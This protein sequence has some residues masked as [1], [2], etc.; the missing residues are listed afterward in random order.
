MN[1][2]L[3]Y[4]QAIRAGSVIVGKWVRLWYEYIVRGLEEGR[5]TFDPKR[6]D[7]AI[8]FIERFCHHCEGRSD[9]LK[10]ALW[11]KALVSV[12][13]GILDQNGSRQFREA[14]VIVAR[15]QGKTLFAAAIIAYMVYL[16]GEYG[17]KVYCIA[18]KL[19]QAA[20]VYDDFCQMVQ[21]EPELAQLSKKRRSDLYVPEWNASVRPIAFNAK[22]SDGFNPQLVVC[23]EIASW[24]AEQGLKQYE[25]MKSALGARR[26]PLVLSISTAGYINDGIY[27]ELLKRCTTVLLGAS[28]EQRLAPFLYMI[29]DLDRW[30]DL[31][32]LA[33][34]NPNL[35]VSVSADYLLEEIAIAEG[36]LSKKTEFLTK[37]CNVKQSSAQAWLPYD[38]IQASCGAALS[39][40]DFRGSYCVGGI[41]LS[42]TTDL[43]ACCVVIEKGGRLYVFSHFF[44][45]RSRLE[46][47][48][49]EDG[50]PYGI[51]LQ[52]GFLTLSGEN[53][54]DYHDCYDWFVRL[55]R[56]YEILPLQVGYDRY[57]AQ[58]LVQEME[59]C[60]F[61]MDDVFQGFNLTPV[62]REFEGILRDGRL[63]IGDNH[64]LQA[65]LL[66][67]ALKLEAEH[68]KVRLIKMGP[69]KRIDGA[70]AL[71]DAMTVRQKW[72]GEIG[73]QLRNEG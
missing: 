21:A 24:P 19:E 12:L 30:N 60:G 29:D 36:S 33:K 25:V 9:L 54:V 35:G 23:D 6:A 5:F 31:D 42:Q 39:L 46:V 20:V 67:A 2:I 16:D 17:A 3:A 66:N 59:A 62:I 65:H 64:L 38:V 1:S 71:L 13:F 47:R 63:S 28:K 55:V 41:D 52:R 14:V 18:P 70:A 8:K 58:Y 34:A 57:S 32:E 45:P 68:Q 40:E 7:K 4:V 26:Q 72:Y 73:S 27:D 44:M 48:T 49:A 11:Q 43:T 50:V 37:Y 51:F 56:D 22:K 69:R 10:L 15:K 61:H 53:Y